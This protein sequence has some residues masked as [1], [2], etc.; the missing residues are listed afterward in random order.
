MNKIVVWFYFLKIIKMIKKI[1]SKIWWNVKHEEVEK[2]IDDS[3]TRYHNRMEDAQR[4]IE[5]KNIVLGDEVIC[6]RKLDWID[7]WKWKFTGE[8]CKNYDYKNIRY[9][10]EFERN[11]MKRT[12]PIHIDQIEKL[13]KNKKKSFYSKK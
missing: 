3:R 10:V 4:R 12:F 2:N 6:T 11:W 9:Y 8:V 13:N 7:K 5:E 1:F